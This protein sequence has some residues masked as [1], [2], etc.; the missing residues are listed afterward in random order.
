MPIICKCDMCGKTSENVPFTDA[1]INISVKNYKGA[2]FRVRINV[3]LE[4][5]EHMEDV[6]KF[7]RIWHG[8]ERID[9]S[10]DALLDF[11]D[12]IKRIEEGEKNLPEICDLCKKE[13]SSRAF[14]EGNFLDATPSFYGK[15][16][17]GEDQ[18][19]ES[20]DDISKIDSF[21]KPK[22]DD[23]DDPEASGGNGRIGFN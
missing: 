18:W 15:T 1:P 11:T 12:M 7:R 10:K 6:A 20:W 3:T 17:L 14:T 23:K 22:K 16:K 5:D 21:F 19:G 2:A 13:F 9:K 8:K 4:H